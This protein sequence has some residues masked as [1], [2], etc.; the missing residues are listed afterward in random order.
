MSSAYGEDLAYIHDRG[1][2]GFAEGLAPGLLSTFKAA[3]LT[4]GT[5]VDLG[6][7]SGIWAERLVDAGYAAVGVDISSAMI[8]LARARVPLATFHIGSFVDFEMPDCSAVT[9]L[10]EVVCYLFD[11][12]N[13]GPALRNL[14]A[15][16]HRA[17]I[18]GG[19]LIFDVAEVGLGRERPPA[20]TE[21]DDWACFVRYEYEELHD[22]L[23]RRITTFRKVGEHYRRDFETHCQQLYEPA[24]VAAWLRE[25]GFEVEI[26]NQFGGFPLL[27]QRSGFIA[28]KR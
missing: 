14:F 19:L 28:H 9:A 22:V 18:P 27:P 23:T 10:G 16:V 3:G 15:Q 5:V 26:V 1:Y 12:S 7:G 17:L 2:V 20:A 25:T 6:C 21:G 4:K 11:A 8:E 13:G 24:A